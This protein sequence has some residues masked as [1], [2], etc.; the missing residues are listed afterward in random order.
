M[1]KKNKVSMQVGNNFQ[2]YT[3]IYV[4]TYT[5]LYILVNVTVNRGEFFSTFLYMM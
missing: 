2:L 3:E 5:Y 4:G 1:S